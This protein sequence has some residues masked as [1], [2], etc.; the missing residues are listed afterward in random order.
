[1]GV[2]SP[3]STPL[4]R[5]PTVSPNSPW[6]LSLPSEEPESLKLDSCFTLDPVPS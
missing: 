6:L 1:M 2:A 4:P 5:C 3:R